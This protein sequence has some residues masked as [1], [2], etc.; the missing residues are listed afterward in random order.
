MQRTANRGEA[1]PG[2]A[3]CHPPDTEGKQ[4]TDAVDT[5][6]SGPRA[7]AS[8][9]LQGKLGGRRRNNATVTRTRDARALR[10]TVLRGL[11]EASTDT[12]PPCR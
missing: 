12:R 5:L 6:A 1:H 2:R 7:R 4:Y 10:E 9:T 3:A 11:A 8:Q